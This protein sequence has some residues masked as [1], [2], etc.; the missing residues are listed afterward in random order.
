[1][2]ITILLT[3]YNQKEYLYEAIDSV[4]M[5]TY[6]RIQLIIADDGTKEFETEVVEKYINEKKKDNI[7][8]FIILHSASN[9]GTVKN[10]NHARQYIKGDL[11]VPLAGDDAFYSKYSIEKYADAVTR[12]GNKCVLV[13]QVKH[14]DNKMQ[15]EMFDLITKKQIEAINTDDTHELYGKVCKDCF[16]PAVGSAYPSEILNRMGP[17]DEGCVLVED[18]LFYL[19]A[20]RK[21]IDFKYIDFVSVKHRDGG[22]S[23]NKKR[24]KDEMRDQ[25]HKDLQYIIK[26]EI[27]RNY[28]YAPEKERKSI[29]HYAHDKI[30]INEFRLHFMELNFEQKLK[31]IWKNL[32]LPMVILRGIQRKIYTKVVKGQ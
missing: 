18:W 1:M 14:F 26:N 23:H 22:V 28:T 7:I 12:Y 9:R 30:V 10:M 13:S 5:Q 6:E 21:G 24:K 11:V 16:I 20:I 8:D 25:Y 4:L 27:L 3:T 32:D 31:W 2:I 15:Y 19:K 29:Y 17:Y